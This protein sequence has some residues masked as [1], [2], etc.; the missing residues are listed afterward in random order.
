[1]EQIKITIRNGKRS[2]EALGFVGPACEA[3]V[4]HVMSKLGGEIV[5]AENTP[6]YYRDPAAEQEQG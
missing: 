2:I 3:A 4:R 5:E 1:M 6:D